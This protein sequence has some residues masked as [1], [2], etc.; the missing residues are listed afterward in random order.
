MRRPQPGAGDA[1]RDLELG[2]D[3]TVSAELSS[4]LRGTI[5]LDLM[6]LVALYLTVTRGPGSSDPAARRR[7]SRYYAAAIAIQGV[8]FAEEWAAEFHVRFPVLL[9][10]EPWSIELWAGFNLAWILIWCLSLVGLR[11]CWRP[12]LLPVWFLAVASVANCVAHPLL[13]LAAD[14]Y[15]P[16]LWSSPLCGLI[17]LPLLALLARFT[18]PG[19]VSLDL[20]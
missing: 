12:A 8:H 6:L 20:A 3:L 7:V 17:G 2:H 4:F 1:V 9:G 16:G 15:F 14:G 18:L 11:L 19:D 13:A 5:A 10:L